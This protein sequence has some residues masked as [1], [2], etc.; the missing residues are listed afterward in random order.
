LAV[1][2]QVWERAGVPLKFQVGDFI[3]G[4]AVLS[5]FRRSADLDERPLE[6]GDAPEPPPCLDQADGYVV[7]SQ[8]LASRLPVFAARRDAILYAPRQYRRFTVDLTGTFEQYMAAF[9][10]KTRSNLKRKLRKFAEVSGGAIDWK[11]YRTPEEIEEFFPLARKVSAKTYQ[12]RRFRSGLPNAAAFVEA[13][14]QSSRDD[15]VRAYLLYFNGEPISYLYSPIVRGVVLYDYL[16]YDP[17]YASLSPGTVLQILVLQALFAERRFLMFDFT[18]GEGQHKEVFSTQS[19]L[20]GDV[21]VVNRRLAPLSVVML[22]RA[23]DGISTATGA[24]LE[25]LTLKSRARRLLRRL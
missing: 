4:S 6:V 17:A 8:P 2:E 14:R 1:A 20:C 18:E 5:L 16:G 11:A 7:W 23:V 3:L 10:G 9:S 12:E 22:H 15:R 19:L 25:R 24:A 13:A 21:F